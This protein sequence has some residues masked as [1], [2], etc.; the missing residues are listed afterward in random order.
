M[1]AW[2]N[3]AIY[4]FWGGCKMTD[5]GQEAL[6]VMNR[7]LLNQQQLKMKLERM[8][9]NKIADLSKNVERLQEQLNEAV[10]TTK[11]QELIIKKLKRRRIC[12]NQ[13]TKARKEHINELIE[14]IKELKEELAR[15]GHLIN[16]LKTQRKEA[17]E[18]IKTTNRISGNI[19][20]SQLVYEDRRKIDSITMQTESYLEKWGVK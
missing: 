1:Y 19:D 4:S 13:K 3:D 6:E 5:L 8:G 15:R 16:E 17:N 14:Q 2:C 10:K 12:D 11:D 7:L 20:L 18:V 9:D